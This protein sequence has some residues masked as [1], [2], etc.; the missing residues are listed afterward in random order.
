MFCSVLQLYQ[1]VSAGLF[2]GTETLMVNWLNPRRVHSAS[3]P[4]R[5]QVVMQSVRD[6]DDFPEEGGA[7]QIRLCSVT[8]RQAV[9]EAV[10]RRTCLCAAV[11]GGRLFMEEHGEARRCRCS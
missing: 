8:H 1:F 7:P 11:K 10:W 3:T 6:V 9:T 5:A 2:R 4:V